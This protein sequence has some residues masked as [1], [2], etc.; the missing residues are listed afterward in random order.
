MGSKAK[1]WRFDPNTGK[2]WLIKPNRRR[3]DDGTCTGDDWSEKLAS[4]VAA[5]LGI[6]HAHTELAICDGQRGI[7]SMDFIADSRRFSLTHGNELLSVEFPGY[8]KG[9]R[10]NVSQHTIVN[11]FRA[12]NSDFIHVSSATDLPAG[13]VCPA[14][15]FVGYLM[16]DA[17]IGNVDR[18][19]ENWAIIEP[20]GRSEDVH[21]ATLAP[22]F[23]HAAGLGSILTDENRARGLSGEKPSWAPATYLGRGRSAFYASDEDATPLTP[24]QA[25][26]HAREPYRPAG[27]AWL[28]RLAELPDE[29]FMQLIASIPE[30]TMSPV[31]RRYVLALLQSG[32][33]ALLRTHREGP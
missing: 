21:H 20:L 27:D 25:F 33:A 6:P 32:R 26:S 29:T 19:H 30:D 23:D 7:I 17:L 18:H 13:V 14:D 31:A 1:D 4:S 24:F 28:Q 10:W 15:V 16:L 11:V 3:S 12:L 2:R 22:T 9:Q 8:P 5:R